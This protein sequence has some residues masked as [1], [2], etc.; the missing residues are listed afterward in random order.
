MFMKKFFKTSD[1]LFNKKVVSKEVRYCQNIIYV[2]KN[3]DDVYY[4]GETS[5]T[6]IERIKNHLRKKGT[7]FEKAINKKNMDEFEW[8][9]LESGLPDSKERFER[10]IYYIE[11]YNSFHNGF[12]MTKGGGGTR[13][14][15][16]TEEHIEKN[17]LA[18]IKHFENPE[19]RKKQSKATSL[20]YA[21][22]PEQ[23]KEHSRL[24][25]K[26]FDSNTKEGKTRRELTSKKQREHYE[27]N[28]V[29][30]VLN[31]KK[32]PFFAYKDGKYIGIFISQSECSRM[33]NVSK[34]H[35]NIVLSGKRK[36]TGGYEFK[37]MDKTGYLF[38]D[39]NI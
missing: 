35:L 30:Y 21:I 11:K 5:Q 9:I 8:T 31:Y 22:N 3:K 15:I 17:R 27:K 39:L 33:L 20:A 2:V 23:A 29:K 38:K 24:M 1:I 14:I 4:V 12:N 10:E 37:Y 26:K 13:G 16:H 7:D 34:S 18:K 6:F 25:K 19:N 32:P 36:T 28:K